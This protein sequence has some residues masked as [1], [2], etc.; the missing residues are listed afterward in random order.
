MVGAMVTVRLPPDPPRLIADSGTRAALVLAAVTTSPAAGVSASDTVNP[1]APVTPFSATVWFDTDEI[2]GGVFAGGG[3]GEF[4]GGGTVTVNVSVS[5][6]PPPSV[7]VRVIDAVPVSPMAGVIVTVRLPPVPPRVIADC[8][9]RVVLVLDA[10]T[11]SP[12]AGVSASDTVNPTAPEVPFS[13]T[14]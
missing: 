8:G 1:T 6:N 13:A 9:N 14:V 2:C 10:V 3:G 7:T 11:T 5:I 12:V 4:G